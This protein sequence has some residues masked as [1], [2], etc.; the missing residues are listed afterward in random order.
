VEFKLEKTSTGTLLTVTESGF[1]KLPADRR[2]EAFR[3]NDN[4]WT[5]QTTNIETYAAQ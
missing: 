4:G 2:D 5:I 1:D 3:M